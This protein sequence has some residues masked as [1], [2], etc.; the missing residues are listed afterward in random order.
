MKAL[1]I[2]AVFAVAFLN[3]EVRK[4]YIIILKLLITKH[5]PNKI[6]MIN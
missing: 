2:V 1:S 6:D 5:K 3:I 4:K